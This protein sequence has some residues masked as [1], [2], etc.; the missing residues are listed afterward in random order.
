MA[1]RAFC[2][3]ISNM[4]RWNRLPLTLSSRLHQEVLLHH[5]R[6]LNLLGTSK[7]SEWNK[8]VSEA[9]K[10]VGY[11]TSF[12]SL[13]CLLS[14]EL[15]NVAM[16]MRKLV[17]TKHPLLKTARKFFYGKH[18]MQ[19]R[20]LLVL[21]VSKTSGP[22]IQ[23]EVDAEL[24]D[25]AISGIYQSQRSLAEITEMINTANLIHKGVVN[26][27]TIQPD[28]GSLNDMHFGNKM[29]VLSGDFLLA[30]ASTG[31][32][33]LQNTHVVEI[34]ASAIGDLMEG[35]FTKFRDKNGN[36]VLP[37][38]G[39]TLS[40]WE[41]Q[42]FCNTG[43]LIA[44][45]CK[46]AL[47][48]AH[49]PTDMQ[50]L[51]YEFGK[52]MAYIHQLNEDMQPFVSSSLFGDDTNGASITSAPVVLCYQNHRDTFEDLG[53]LG[54]PL[55]N[56]TKLIRLIENSSAVEECRDLC[57]SYSRQALDLL[58]QFPASEARDALERMIRAATL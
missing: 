23:N 46:A 48:L 9:E 50:E 39:A 26:L 27:S 38:E 56:S 43:C 28:D 33:N 24:E 41:N 19:T 20:G 13:R 35:E 18:S 4:G 12:M 31:L 42:T 6:S 45:S 47:M 51:A 52:C 11:P 10:I 44:K 58:S 22:G 29:A 40:D 8:A 30:S 32:A 5:S 49:H 54:K 14:D 25:A 17:G 57:A 2:R 55:D 53:F 1:A 34:M 21:L 3:V 16:Q 37:V 7:V 15:S 36:P